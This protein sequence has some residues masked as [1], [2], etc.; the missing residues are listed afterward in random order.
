MIASVD[1][2]GDGQLTF[3][4]FSSLLRS[5][6]LSDEAR[7]GRTSRGNE[8]RRDSFINVG[9][10]P[11]RRTGTH[12]QSHGSRT[13]TTHSSHSSQDRLAECA[14]YNGPLRTLAR[15]KKAGHSTP[16]ADER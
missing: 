4:Q 9:A 1:V 6:I 15:G 3:A 5:V 2:E 7:V 16:R 11:A 10:S 13:A 14:Q 12:A 8:S